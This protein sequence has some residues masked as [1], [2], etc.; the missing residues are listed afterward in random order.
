MSHEHCS[1]LNERT[2]KKQLE[3]L[4]ATLKNGSVCGNDVKSNS[5]RFFMKQSLRRGEHIESQCYNSDSGIKGGRASTQ[6]DCAIFYEID[7]IVS[8]GE[9][10]QKRDAGGKNPLLVCRHCFKKSIGTPSSGIRASM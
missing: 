3:G 5:S 8:A 4:E 1:Q 10:R 9:T 2:C 6:D 7:D